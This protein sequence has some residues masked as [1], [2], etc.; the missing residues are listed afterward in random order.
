[1]NNKIASELDTATAAA[2]N[3]IRNGRDTSRLANFQYDSATTAPHT[4]QKM[5][6]FKQPN[7]VC[8]QR[9][10]HTHSH[11]TRSFA[12]A[13]TVSTSV[14]ISFIYMLIL[15]IIPW[16]NKEEKER[17]WWL[18]LLLLLFSFFLSFFYSKPKMFG[19][20]GE[21][22]KASCSWNNHKNE[23]YLFN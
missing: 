18:A 12:Q 4:Y 19:W 7:C 14:H 10:R 20:M 9:E 17:M 1:M 3:G 15:M 23:K 22:K 21:H 11:S 6:V 16:P 2:A 8:T 5:V 13:F